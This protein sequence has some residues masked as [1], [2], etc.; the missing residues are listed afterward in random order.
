MSNSFLRLSALP[1]DGADLISSSRR[2]SALFFWDDEKGPVRK[3][4]S[5]CN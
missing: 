3:G 4:V 2:K 1:H 5:R